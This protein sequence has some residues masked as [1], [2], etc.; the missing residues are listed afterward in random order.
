MKQTKTL[1]FLFSL[2][3]SMHCKGVG[4]IQRVVTL[5][6]SPKCIIWRNTKLID[7]PVGHSPGIRYQVHIKRS[8]PGF[9]WVSV[10]FLFSVKNH[11]VPSFLTSR[12]SLSIIAVNHLDSFIP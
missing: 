9:P 10:H 12:V 8:T 1:I 7:R 5:S 2:V 6:V 4:V 11:G 3:I